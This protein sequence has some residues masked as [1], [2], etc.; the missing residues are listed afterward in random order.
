MKKLFSLFLLLTVLSGCISQV[1]VAVTDNTDSSKRGEACNLF[2]LLPI[3]GNSSV[4]EAKKNGGITKVATV[5]YEVRWYLPYI[6]QA[7]TIV[8]GS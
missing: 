5:D 3:F 6:F 1:P 7:C 2:V 8:T 4:V